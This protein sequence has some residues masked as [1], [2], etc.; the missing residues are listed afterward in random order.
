MLIECAGF[1]WHRKYVDWS[2]RQLLGVSEDGG[3]EAEIDFANQSAIYGLYDDS[4]HCIYVGQAGKG[5]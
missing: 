5:E 3:S 1:M 2:R 4:G